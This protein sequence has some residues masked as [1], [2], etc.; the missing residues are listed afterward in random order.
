MKIIL[1]IGFFILICVKVGY[2][3]EDRWQYIT[4]TE[5]DLNGEYSI[6]YVDKTS[7]EEQTTHNGVRTI[8]YWE[9]IKYYG[10]KDIDYMMVYN[11]INCNEKI[12][13]LKNYTS[14]FY[15]GGIIS[16]ENFNYIERV[17]PETVGEITFNFICK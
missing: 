16:K 14:Y 1:L 9:K 15:D 3:Q 13:I 2:S 11:E 12:I 17:V 5:P 10:T 8:R 4:E 7:I 6:S